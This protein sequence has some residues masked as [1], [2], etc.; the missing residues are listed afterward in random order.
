MCPHFRIKTKKT[1][2]KTRMKTTKTRTKTR[3]KTT[4]TRTKTTVMSSRKS[5]NRRRKKRRRKAKNKTRKKRNNTK[6]TRY[7]ILDYKLV[8]SWCL[9]LDYV[10]MGNRMCP[11]LP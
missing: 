5:R 9:L 8:S 10:L 2:T 7:H 1:R 3:M 11:Q 6:W 4:K